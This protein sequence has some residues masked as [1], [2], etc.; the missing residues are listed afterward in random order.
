MIAIDNSLID[1]QVIVHFLQKPPTWLA[2]LG[3]KHDCSNDYQS[4]DL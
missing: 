4:L 1:S 3:N 2:L